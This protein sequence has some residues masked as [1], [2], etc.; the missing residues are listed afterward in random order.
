MKTMYILPDTKDRRLPTPSSARTFES[1]HFDLLADSSEILWGW[2]IPSGFFVLSVGARVALGLDGDGQPSTM[3]DFTAHIP[4]ACVE[5]Y[6]ER[7]E[8]VLNG[9]TGSILESAYPIGEL[10]VREYLMVIQRDDHG[11]ATH[12]L[13][14]CNASTAN[15]AYTPPLAVTPTDKAVTTGYWWTTLDGVIHLDASCA[16]LLGFAN[17][18]PMS[19]NQTQWLSRMHPD[20]SKLDRLSLLV[21]H[22][23]TGDAIEDALRI[24]CENG[25]YAH[26]LFRGAVMERNAAGRALSIVGTLQR[27]DQF[28]RETV[29]TGQLLS[30]IHATGDGLWDW[31]STTNK[32]YYNSR[33]LSMLGYTAEEFP[34][35][36]DVWI[37]KIHPEDVDKIVQPQKD[38]VASPR[39][40]DTFECTYRL[41]CKDGTWAWILGRGYVAHRDAD[42]K[43]TRLV[44]THTNI[45]AVQNE[46]ERLENLIKNDALTGLRSRA[47]CEKEIERLD[48]NLIRP[49]SVVS[50]DVNGLKLVNDYLGHSEGDRLLS[51]VALMLRHGLRATDCVA[52]VGGDEFM[53]LFPGC[54]EEAASRILQKITSNI[55]NTNLH[56]DELPVLISFGL[57]TTLDEC[58]SISKAFAEADRRMLRS[59]A[60]SR[61]LSQRRI[62][63][64]IRQH[65]EVTVNLADERYES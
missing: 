65:A 3:E 19:L 25:E 39:Y 43:A 59:K 20:E 35:T 16:A 38:I 61:K 50:C 48:K 37:A 33:Y 4:A 27:A 15:M 22:S 31:D 53:L 29:E 34:G 11:R 56:S 40:G 57:A 14:S 26:M 23:A 9:L 45:T 17:P 21:E 7:R 8:S 36:L 47:F 52:R 46:R 60:N 63:E 28:R 44:G 42:G 64:W 54:T 10:F 41:L 58:T 51:K 12:V 32:V 1:S 30:A 6:L 49:V 5:T 13:A 24:L 55:D 2:H 62:K 18:R